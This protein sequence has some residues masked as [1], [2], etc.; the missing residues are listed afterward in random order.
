MV[1]RVAAVVAPHVAL[2]QSCMHRTIPDPK[3]GRRAPWLVKGTGMYDLIIRHG[4]IIDGTGAPW[5]SA[6]LAVHD[7]R[8][9]RFGK[10]HDERGQR[11]LDASERLVTPG[12]IDAHTHSDFTLLI[13]A[14]ASSSVAQGVTTQVMGHCG[15][16]AAPLAGGEPYYGP[17]DP[18]LTRGL[19]CDWKDMGTYLD[20]LERDGL[21]THVA[22]LVGHGNLRTA[23]VGLDDREATPEELQRMQALLAEALEAG[24]CGLSSGLAYAPGPYAPLSELVALG[25]VVGRH[26][27]LYTSHIRNQ[28]AGIAAAVNEV[29]TVGRDGQVAAHISHM[30]PGSPMLG[31]TQDLLGMLETAR[32]GGT[33]VSCDA[34]PYTIGSTTL[35]SMLPPWACAGGD[36]A[37][38]RRLQDP[39]TRTRIKADTER[40]GAESGG[41]RKRNL[42]RDAEWD[43]IW[44]AQAEHNADLAGLSFAEIG[45]QRRQEPHEALLDILLEEDARPW[46]LAEDVA[47]EDIVNIVR[48]DAG[49]IMSDGFSLAADGPLSGGRNHPR[50]YAAFPRF[51]RRFVREQAC[52]SWEAAIHKLTA[53]PASRC[54]LHDRGVLRPGAWADIVVLDPET[55]TETATFDCP[56]S[57]PRGIEHVLVNGRFVVDSGRLTADRPGRVL[58]AGR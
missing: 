46:M 43:R 56:A 26:G 53:H 35:K 10:L 36:A 17:L 55:I 3:D 14:R 38:L 25:T 39:A 16:S 4:R 18:G 51:L 23:V 41:S 24:A 8:I 21:G 58:R 11:E 19:I 37:L 6:D 9:V 28:T 57:Y 31:A 1:L 30:Q 54:R 44:L 32:A 48:H 13:D 40:H 49:G 2:P 50:S 29:I 12:F 33:D 42:I 34:I 15:V 52:L 5:I 47:E 27:G 22:T 45:R 7:G 20:R